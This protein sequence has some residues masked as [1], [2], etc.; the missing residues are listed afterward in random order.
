MRSSRSSERTPR[1]L[2]EPAKDPIELAARALGRHE[3]SRREL[4]DRLARAGIGE[5]A[6]E[7]AL[8]ALERFGYLDDARVAASRAETL[9]S[10]GQGDEAIRVDLEQRGIDPVLAEEAL[11][12]LEPEAARAAALVERLGRTAKAAAQLRR[13]G[14]SEDSVESA[15]GGEIAA[16]GL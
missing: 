10:R 2:P 4:D 13:K 16:G 5:A 1:H 15:L 12:G 3:R 9:A 11:A 6:R 7:Q 8:E 14:F